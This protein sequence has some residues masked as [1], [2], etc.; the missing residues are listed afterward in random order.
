MLFLAM[1][2]AA[3]LDFA[4][5]MTFVPLINSGVIYEKND[6]IYEVGLAQWALEDFTITALMIGLFSFMDYLIQIKFRNLNYVVPSILSFLI[7][8]R[9]GVSVSNLL[10]YATYS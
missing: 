1:I 7:I 3:T 5:T 8:F 4:S 6:R 9:F 2:L 10:L